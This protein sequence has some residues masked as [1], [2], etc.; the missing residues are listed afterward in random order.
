MD[1]K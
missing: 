1:P